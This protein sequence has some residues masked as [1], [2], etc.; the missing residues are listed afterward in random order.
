MK[1]PSAARAST[2]CLINSI[3]R[4]YGT[5]SRPGP[6]TPGRSSGL[7]PPEVNGWKRPPGGPAHLLRCGRPRPPPT[8]P[9]LGAEQAWLSEP[10]DG[11]SPASEVTRTEASIQKDRLALAGGGEPRSTHA[12]LGPEGDE[13][14]R[15]RVSLAGSPCPRRC[16]HS[17][18]GEGV[19]HGR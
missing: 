6:S 3:P 10:A 8:E 18:P 11:A 19:P 15:P 2:K 12:S 4:E 5:F 9:F 14:D 17:R 7:C 13:A 16:P 1:D